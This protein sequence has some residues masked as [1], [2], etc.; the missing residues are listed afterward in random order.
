MKN[1]FKKIWSRMRAKDTWNEKFEV[2]CNSFQFGKFAESEKL[3]QEALAS[4]DQ[5]KKG[6]PRLFSTLVCIGA[7]YRAQE[8]FVEAEQVLRQAIELRL[9]DTKSNYKDTAFAYKELSSCLYESGKCDEVE[10]PIRTAIR[11]YEEGAGKDRSECN[12]ELAECFLILART[13]IM[14]CRF[15]EAAPLLEQC[16]LRFELSPEERTFEL[17]DTLT[18]QAI[19][20]NREGQF[21]KSETNLIR[22]LPLHEKLS[23]TESMELARC[24]TELAASLL[25][26]TRYEDAEQQ[27]SEA[28]RIMKKLGSQNSI[29]FADALS[30]LAT[31]FRS[32]RK[33]SQAISFYQQALGI[34]EEHYSFDHDDIATLLIQLAVCFSEQEQFSDAEKLFARAA[35]ISEQSKGETG[36]FSD[37]LF[38]LANC[39]SFQKK[40]EEA[41]PLYHRAIEI[42]ENTIGREHPDFASKLTGLAYCYQLQE[43]YMEAKPLY[44]QALELCEKAKGSEDEISD[45]LIGLANCHLETGDYSSAKPLYERALQF[46]QNKFDPRD[47]ELAGRIE[48]LLKRME[49]SVV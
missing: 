48:V 4:L 47:Q 41:V 1:W 44:T 46:K 2:G 14:S 31:G 36:E 37:M 24:K 33:F 23:G 39:Y 7:C 19:V 17:A 3:F 34:Y 6:D 30:G 8:K 13:L 42:A 27:F 26:Q 32:Q 43:K 25:A 18:C 38:N 12:D 9:S 10:T 49:H 15:T 40:Y 20:W 45:N 11:L 35:K 16:L 28:L 29:D 5:K 21:Q 22:V